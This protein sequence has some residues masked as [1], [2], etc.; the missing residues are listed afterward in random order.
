MWSREELPFSVATDNAESEKNIREFKAE[1]YV[2][3]ADEFM[4][5][6]G[7]IEDGQASKKTA[8]LIEDWI[9]G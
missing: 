1:I 5:K 7:I 4:K 6:H 8:D 9:K 3:S 2:K